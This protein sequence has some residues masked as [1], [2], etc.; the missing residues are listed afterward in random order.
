MRIVLRRN[1]GAQ[2]MS[3]QE[4]TTKFDNFFKTDCM[5][6]LF[7]LLFDLMREFRP[8]NLPNMLN[9]VQLRGLMV[10]S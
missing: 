9:L 10:S 2:V 4:D 7:A 5:L 6:F 1:L 8:A 3:S